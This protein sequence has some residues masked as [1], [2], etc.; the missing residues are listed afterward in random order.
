MLLTWNARTANREDDT[1]ERQIIHKLV[2]RRVDGIILRPSCEEFQS[3][4]FEEIWERD[5]PLILV[6]REMSFVKTDFVGT[7]DQTGGKQAAEFL[8]SLGHRRLLFAGESEL[9][10]TSRHRKEGFIA[11]VA[12]MPDA[13]CRVLDLGRPEAPAELAEILRSPDRPTGVFAYNDAV[14]ESIVMLAKEAGLEVPRDLSVVGFGNEP[15]P[16]A[17]IALTTFD[18]QPMVIGD[19]A[20]KL[21]LERTNRTGPKKVRRILIEAKLVERQS[22]SQFW[23]GSQ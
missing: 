19:A 5:I 22:T 7:D 9:V 12:G 2:D 4:Y 6:D 11:A 3:S 23:L 17:P 18:Q 15:S 14:G 8:Y 1:W 10:S 21:Y 13:Y 16:S 20:A